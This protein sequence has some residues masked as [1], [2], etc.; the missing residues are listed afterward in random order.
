MVQEVTSQKTGL[1]I[2]VMS[3]P[4]PPTRAGIFDNPGCFCHASCLYRTIH[5]ASSL[6]N[7]RSAEDRSLFHSWITDHRNLVT[8]FT[9]KR[10]ACRDSTVM[11]HTQFKLWN[12]FTV[13]DYTL[14]CKEGNIVLFFFSSVQA[15][16]LTRADTSV[17]NQGLEW[18]QNKTVTSWTAKSMSIGYWLVVESCLALHIY[19][20]AKGK[21]RI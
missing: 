6:W 13:C 3:L 12:P 2:S 21:I 18:K 14:E 11:L 17:C 7:K 19:G 15:E 9:Q 10:V 16:I 1:K 8:K 5:F 4:G 20:E